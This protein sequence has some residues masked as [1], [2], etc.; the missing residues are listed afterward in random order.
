MSR[1]QRDAATDANRSEGASPEAQ[2]SDE[3]IRRIRTFLYELAE[4]TSNYRSLH[5]LTEQVEHHRRFGLRWNWA[6]EQNGVAMS[7]F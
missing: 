5:S 4:G 2:I 1:N 7:S 3:S 6:E